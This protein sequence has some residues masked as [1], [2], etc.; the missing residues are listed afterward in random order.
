MPDVVGRAWGNR[1]NAR[2]RQGR[3]QEALADYNASIA[4]C[5]WSVDPVL[6]RGVAL[7]ALG[8]FEG[9][10][11]VGGAGLCDHRGGFGLVCSWAGGGWL[12]CSPCLNPLITASSTYPNSQ[13]R[14][15]TT[16]PSWR[17]PPTTHRPGTTLATRRRV[18]AGGWMDDGVDEFMLVASG[19]GA[20]G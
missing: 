12:R 8:R 4:L 20:D 2:A 3:L 9:A 17:R 16:A 1:G 11:S 13:R 5:P 14:A 7:E 18:R 19:G 15:L 10:F 6:N